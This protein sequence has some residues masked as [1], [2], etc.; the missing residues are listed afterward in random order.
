MK[1]NEYYFMNLNL[2]ACNN[3]FF[4][5]LGLF[6]LFESMLSEFPHFL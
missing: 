6:R 2:K 3:Y 1:L 5:F 4:Y